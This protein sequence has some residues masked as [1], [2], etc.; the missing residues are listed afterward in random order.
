MNTKAKND[1]EFSLNFLTTNNDYEYNELELCLNAVYDSEYID[2]HV[3]KNNCNILTSERCS[4]YYDD[5]DKIIPICKKYKEYKSYF[6]SLKDIASSI[7]TT[8]DNDNLCSFTT[9]MLYYFDE[10]TFNQTLVNETCKS[11]KCTNGF[12]KLIN[13]LINTYDLES[14]LFKNNID[15]YNEM[16]E[17]F[18]EWKSHLTAK[19]CV[20]QNK[21]DSDKNTDNGSISDNNLNTSGTLK[22][23]YFTLINV[24]IMITSVMIWHIHIVF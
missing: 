10:K 5:I 21:N 19:E 20:S 23:K 6:Q 22:L 4:K 1:F 8:D 17:Y 16:K 11:T 2:C 18:N 9:Q 12:I 13:S 15:L 24:L 7:C 14:D 3:M